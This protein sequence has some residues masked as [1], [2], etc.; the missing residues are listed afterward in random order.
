[1][2]ELLLYQ[3][4][5]IPI[6][7]LALAD[8]K[9]RSIKD[10]HYRIVLILFSFIGLVNIIFNF[11]IFYLAFLLIGV[12]IL[13]ISKKYIKKLIYSADRYIVFFLLFACPFSLFAIGLSFGFIALLIKLK[14]IINTFP[15]IPILLISML[16]VNIILS[17]FLT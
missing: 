10:Y 15:Y 9:Y 1:M 3:I 4:C 2:V 13:F 12:V 8:Y 11:N 16:F 5:I 6:A 17:L 7:L 14:R